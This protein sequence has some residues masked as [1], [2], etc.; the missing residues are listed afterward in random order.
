MVRKKQIKYKAKCESH[1]AVA[2]T[3]GDGFLTLDEV[4]AGSTYQ[5]E[6]EDRAEQLAFFAKMDTD[7]DGKVTI[8]EVHAFFA[9]QMDKAVN[10]A[11][12]AVADEKAKRQAA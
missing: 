11:E 2:N 1:F 3:A 5:E 4:R 8:E 7:G 10:D 12:I 6:S 9:A